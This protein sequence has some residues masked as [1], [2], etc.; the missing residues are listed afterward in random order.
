MM[1]RREFLLGGRR[2]GAWRRG[3]RR[4]AAER[5]QAGG[6]EGRPAEDR[7]RPADLQLD[8]VHEP[9][10][11]RAFEK[12]YGVKVTVSNFDSMPGM[13][14]KLRA[15]N[16]YDL[17]FPT[18]DYVNRLKGRRCC[19]RSTAG[20]CGT[21]ARSTRSSTT[22]GTT[23]TRRTP[24]RTRCTRRASR[25]ARTRS[26]GST[27]PG[28]T[29]RSRR[30]RAGRSCS[31]TSR[32]GSGRRTSST[33]STST[34]PTP[35]RARAEQ[36]DARAPEGV[37]AR[38]L[39]ATRRRTCVSGTAWV[40][41][42]WNGDII[43]VRNQSKEPENLRFQTCT[44]GIPVGSD[45]MAIP[46]QRAPSGHRAAVHRL[47]ARPR[48]RLAEHRVLRLPDADQGLRGRRSPSSPP[49]TRRSR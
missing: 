34:R 5:A 12:T 15:G 21:A 43:N 39:H 23:R 9:E 35:A 17:I 26:A 16:R 20:C 25:G 6:A 11:D 10:G 36:G 24:C 2:G 45:C 28:T 18:A 4:G 38:L 31:T 44:E 13:M 49:T 7:R 48:A 30:R 42:A 14:A 32:R 27:A 8:R 33:A 37:P 22:R 47:D 1:R 19:S 46:V 3:L 41:H 40:H 29:S